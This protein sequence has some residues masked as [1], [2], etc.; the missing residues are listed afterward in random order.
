MALIRQTLIRQA[1]RNP[2]ARAVDRAE[3]TAT[4][5]LIALWL[6][7][8]PVVAVVGS[9]M[10]QD[11]SAAAQD[12]RHSRSTTTA[13]LLQDAPELTFDDQAMPMTELVR[14]QARWSAPDGSERTGAVTT[15]AGGRT[16]DRTEIWVDRTGDAVT[17]PVDSLSAAVLII[18][19]TAFGA[20]LWGGLLAAIQYT[21]RGRLDR[22]RMA[23]WDDDWR[24]I[25]PLWSGRHGG[26]QS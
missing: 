13:Q 5:L 6:V 7:T 11:V 8:L 22:R 2:L 19:L 4:V 3:A 26:A 21:F 12:E 10:W 25:E 17:A 23:G 14:A 18:T 24:R 15:A 9:L 16:G 20:L 1:W